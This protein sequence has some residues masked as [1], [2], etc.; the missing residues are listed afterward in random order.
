MHYRELFVV[1][2]NGSSP[3]HNTQAL[4]LIASGAVPVEDL[5]THRVPLDRVLEAIAAVTSGAAVKVV[6]EP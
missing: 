6:V 2:V 3:A 1:G 5:I 4:D